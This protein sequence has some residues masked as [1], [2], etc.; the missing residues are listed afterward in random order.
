[1]PVVKT[2]R[3]LCANCLRQ[4]PDLGIGREGRGATCA[5][6]GCSPLPS[7]KFPAKHFAHPKR[8]KCEVK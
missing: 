1:M 4:Q 5:Y 8:C 3:V 6:C 7:Y 2:K